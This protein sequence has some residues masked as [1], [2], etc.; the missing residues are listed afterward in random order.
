MRE[1]V[2]QYPSC[3]K[4]CRSLTG[5]VKKLLI[6]GVDLSRYVE[7]WMAGLA[8]GLGPDTVQPSTRCPLT[9]NEV[10]SNLGRLGGP[11]VDTGDWFVG[12]HPCKI[13]RRDL[14][15]SHEVC[16]VSDWQRNPSDGF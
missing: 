10:R 4:Y 14:T 7:Q 3:K 16:V 6:N 5:V 1:E 15:H 11:G 8:C 9:D 2:P 13:H 12:G